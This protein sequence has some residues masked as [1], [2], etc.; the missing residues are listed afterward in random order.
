MHEHDKPRSVFGEIMTDSPRSPRDKAERPDV[1]DAEFETIDRESLPA[2]PLFGTRKTAKGMDFLTQPPAADTPAPR[3]GGA[4]FWASGLTL[5]VL[6]FW[7]SGG[8]ALVRQAVLAVPVETIHPLQIA[9]VESRVESH[10]GR[11]V[12]FVSG[13]A[14]NHGATTQPLPPIEIAVIANDGAVT[15]YYL[16]TSEAELTPGG[17]YAFSSRLEPPRNGVKIVAVTF[18][19]VRR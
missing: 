1:A 9:G 5:V 13:A 15:R 7:V 12:L 6:A 10:N 11:D 17:R 16:G 4:L 18:Q 14:E 2:A 8:H 3:N 19:E